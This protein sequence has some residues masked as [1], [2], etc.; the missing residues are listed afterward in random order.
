MPGLA[1]ID[2][3]LIDDRYKGIPGGTSPFPLAE[4]GRRGWNV[5]RGDLPLP[6]AVLKESALSHNSRWMQ[7]FLALS[8]AKFAPHGKTTMAPQLFQR[9]LDDGAWGI[10]LATMQ[11]VQVA[12][13]FGFSRILL[14]NEVVDP[15]AVE[16]VIEELARDERFEFWCLVDSVSNVELLASAVKKQRLSRPF[17]VLLE[18]GLSGGR[19][20]C[21]S[22]DDALKVAR[23]VRSHSP[24]LALRGV[25]GFEGIISEPTPAESSIK[26]RAFLGFLLEVAR[27]CEEERL[28]AEESVI[29]SA[30]GSEFFD[31]VADI[32][33][34]SGLR[35]ETEIIIRSGC[36]L[37]HDSDLFI[38]LHNRLQDRTPAAKNIGDPPR[39]ALELWTHVLSRPE[40]TRAILGLGKRDASHDARLPLPV[41]WYRPGLHALPQPIPPGHATF[42]LHDQHALL[43]VPEES[44][45]QVGDLVACGISHPCTTFDKWR[46]LALVDDRYN[47]TG[48]I[49]TFF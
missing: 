7:K 37:T 41:L 4:I 10:T 28:F 16:Y 19:A 31:L 21:R 20:G 6:I 11:Q 2:D 3:L 47:V 12:R 14:A 5:L 32:L 45:L 48:G 22:M 43:N 35:R 1:V 9:Q 34:K 46:L 17:E 23:A 13:R 27:R 49:H 36:Y 39:G 38:E 15:S 26:V 8:G 25:E 24:N 44:P 29:I 18:V 40:P 42:K 33:P 30:G